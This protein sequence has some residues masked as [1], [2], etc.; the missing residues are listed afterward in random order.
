MTTSTGPT[1]FRAV[2]NRIHRDGRG[3]T[4]MPVRHCEGVVFEGP[5]GAKALAAHRKEFHGGGSAL[6]TRPAWLG[7]GTPTPWAP[8]RRTA[9]GLEK[10]VE[11]I[12]A[13]DY[14]LRGGYG[15]PEFLRF[16]ES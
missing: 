16:A 13:G 5:E 10:V 11:R 8:P 4:A 14:D 9:G 3:R 1:T 7:N 12:K 6:K 15:D 2:C